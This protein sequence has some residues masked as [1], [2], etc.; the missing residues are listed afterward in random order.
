MN[1]TVS[2]SGGHI[3]DIDID[4]NAPHMAFSAEDQ[5]HVIDELL[6]EAVRKARLAYE[7][8]TNEKGK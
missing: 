3:G 8:D 2:I 6:T 4:L 1:V 5:R 7:I